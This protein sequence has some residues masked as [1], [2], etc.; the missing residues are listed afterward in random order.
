MKAF[1]GKVPYFFK[2]CIFDEKTSDGWAGKGN[3][4]YKVTTMAREGEKGVYKPGRGVYNVEPVGNEVLPW[5]T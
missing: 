5:E 4:I 2:W 3:N 1:A